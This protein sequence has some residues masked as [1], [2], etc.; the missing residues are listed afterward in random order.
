MRKPKSTDLGE[1]LC[2]GR[3]LASIETVKNSAK[4]AAGVAAPLVPRSV[5]FEL[6]ALYNKAI[7]MEM[8]CWAE[9]ERERNKK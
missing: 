1:G 8:V 9:Y 3:L 5:K 2:W 7:E 4:L 6:D